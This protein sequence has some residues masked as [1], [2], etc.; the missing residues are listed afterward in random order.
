M[1]DILPD[2][3]KGR[4]EMVS[5]TSKANQPYY[6]TFHR[7]PRDLSRWT[8]A[9][10]GNSKYELRFYDRRLTLKKPMR[11]EHYIQY[12]NNLYEGAGNVLRMEMEFRKGNPLKMFTMGFFKKFT[13]M[14]QL[15]KECM[16][17]FHKHHRLR[18]KKS[19]KEHINWAVLFFSDNYKSLKECERELDLD[20]SFEQ[21]RFYETNKDWESALHMLAKRLVAAGKTSDEDI[22]RIRFLLPKAIDGQKGVVAKEK[23][24][25]ES[26]QKIFIEFLKKE[27]STWWEDEL[28]RRTA[29]AE[30]NGFLR[31]IS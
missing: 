20:I 5:N 29:V 4:W 22:K 30:K 1:V 6:R 25:Y 17:L 14:N 18:N 7:D 31:I 8:G 12:Y 15:L 27:N 21:L 26:T 3:K 10:F 23:F 9:N 19:G 13:P 24:Q 2:I 16:A 28:Q 11:K